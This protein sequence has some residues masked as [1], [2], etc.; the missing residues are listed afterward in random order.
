MCLKYK[1]N[2]IKK[3][4]IVEDKIKNDKASPFSKRK[5]HNMLNNSI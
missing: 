5:V 1:K 4:A 2:E 3:T